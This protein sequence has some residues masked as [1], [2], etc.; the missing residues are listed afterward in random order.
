MLQL[1]NQCIVVNVWKM[2]VFFKLKNNL[3]WPLKLLGYV[4]WTSLAMIH[5]HIFFYSS[6]WSSRKCECLSYISSQY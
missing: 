1:C 4:L 2:W 5:I 3:Y 6:R